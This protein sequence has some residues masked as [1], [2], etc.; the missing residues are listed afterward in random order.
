MAVTVV[1]PAVMLEPSPV[2]AGGDLCVLLLVG[3]APLMVESFAFAVGGGLPLGSMVKTWKSV[4]LIT[5]DEAIILGVFSRKSN[6]RVNYFQN[7]CWE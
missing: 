6:M 5:G 7:L 4:G 2:V 3:L 1:A